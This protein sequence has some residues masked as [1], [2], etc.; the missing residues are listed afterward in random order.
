FFEALPERFAE[1][2]RNIVQGLLNGI[3]EQWEALKARIYELGELLPGWLRDRL[4]IASPSK[5]MHEI[6]TQIGHGLANG[7]A[8]TQ[9]L[10]Q[11]AVGSTADQIENTALDAASK[12]VGAMGQMFDQSKPI[13]MAQALIN[14]WQGITEA[15]KLPFPSNLAAAAQVAAQGF[16]AV[17]GIQSTSKSGGGGGSTGA[18]SAAAA[19]AVPTQTVSINL[20]GDTFSRGSVEGLLEQ[21]QSQLDRGGRLVFS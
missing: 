16:A 19:P 6:G 8:D 20:Q 1:F 4:G 11:Q 18:S 17:K 10:A 2:G 13:A 9:A 12:V 14:T 15:L 7:I 3:N 21:I 5:V